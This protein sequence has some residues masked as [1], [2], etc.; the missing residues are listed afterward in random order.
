MRP[1]CLLAKTRDGESVAATMEFSTL[2][3]LLLGTRSGIVGPAARPQRHAECLGDQRRYV[4]S[5]GI[6]EHAAVIRRKVCERLHCLGVDFH[7][8]VDEAGSPVL[9]SPDG[10]VRVLVISTKEEL[11]IVRHRVWLVQGLQQ[12]AG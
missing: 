11:G 1:V 12:S 3:G 2:D 4:F 8:S 6:G 5:G 9:T 10:P 7:T